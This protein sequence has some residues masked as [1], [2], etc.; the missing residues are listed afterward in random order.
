MLTA[1]ISSLFLVKIWN[2]N[3][4]GKILVVAAIPIFILSASLDVLR[5]YIRPGYE[6]WSKEDIKNAEIIKEK[7]SP[8]AIFL[9]SDKHN[10]FIPTLTG[11][12]IIMGYRGWLWTYGINY[13][14]REKEVLAIYQ[15]SE[16]AEN[17]LK[18]YKVDYIVIGPNEKN[19][20]LNFPLFL[21]SDNVKIYKIK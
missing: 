11:R 15:G 18:K 19:Y 21:S 14:K 20:S 5:L 9:T 10:H 4:F 13:S 16:E 7:T 8:D 1:I 17:L 2:K 3:I 6:S 12:Q